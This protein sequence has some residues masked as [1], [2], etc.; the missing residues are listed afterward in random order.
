[1]DANVKDMKHGT[2]KTTDAN[3]AKFSHNRHIKQEDKV[4]I[5]KITKDFVAMCIIRMEHVEL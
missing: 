2:H 4:R 5:R 1:M 3:A